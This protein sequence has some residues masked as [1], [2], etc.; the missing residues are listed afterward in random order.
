MSTPINGD[1]ADVSN[2]PPRWG[3]LRLPRTF[4]AMRHRNFRLFY[5]GQLV[6]LVG[7][8]MQN[9]AQGWLVVLLAAAPGASR[10]QAEA[11]A[12]ASLGLIALAQSLPVLLGGLYGGMV[13]DRRSK[14]S[15]IVVTQSLQMALALATAALI[16]GGQIRV[17]HVVVLALLG[18]IVNV[19]DVPA[20]QSFVIDMVGPKDLPNAIA[21]NS[22]IFNAARAFGPA[23]AGLLIAALERSGQEAALAQCF[24]FNGLSFAAVIAGLLLMRGDF[25]AR[26]IS[27][28]SPLQQVREVRDYLKEKRAA[29]LLIGLVAATSIFVVPYFILLPSLARFTLGVDARRFGLMMSCQGMGALAAALVIAT[30]SE[31]GHKGRVLTLAS[32]AFPTLLVLLALSRNYAASCLLVALIGFALIAF[33]ATANTLLQTSSPDR[34]RGRLMG[35]YSLILMGLTPVGSLW[36]GGVARVWGAPAAI[37]VGGVAAGAFTLLAALRYPAFRRTGRTLPESL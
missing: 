5:F 15:I 33:L 12:N 35:V 21:L 30:I 6:S 20:R 17:W 28:A 24:L 31:A 18:G 22:S 4:A 8:W 27:T 29:L 2:E 34:L 32:L 25:G 9:T 26:A 37:A 11:S 10:A 7:A 3:R 16:V 1:A 23:A 13:A 19:F 14:R 36:A